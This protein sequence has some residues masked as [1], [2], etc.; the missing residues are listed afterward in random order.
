MPW[1]L[2]LKAVPF[3]R[4]EELS[5][6]TVWLTFW[7][8]L[9][10]PWEM[11]TVLALRLRNISERLDI[12]LLSECVTDLDLQ[13][14]MIIFESKLTT[15]KKSIILKGNWCCNENWLEPKTEPLLGNL[16]CPNQWNALYQVLYLSPSHTHTLTYTLTY[17]LIFFLSVFDLLLKQI[18]K[19]YLSFS[20]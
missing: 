17:T 2:F 16:A 6:S 5:P 10:N 11:P 20:N 7:S 8:R 13:I 1:K 9:L 3:S 4:S 19:I 15:F 14:E 18:E 12:L